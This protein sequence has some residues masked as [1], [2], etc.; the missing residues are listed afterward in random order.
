MRALVLAMVVAGCVRA[1][2]SPPAPV[3]GD[4]ELRAELLRIREADQAERERFGEAMA[5]ND[6]AY[7]LRLL[8]ADSARTRRLQEII[9]RHGWPRVARV[10]KD[11]VQGAFLVVQHSPIHEFQREIL[12]QLEVIAKTGEIPAGEVALLTDRV[13]V[14]Q[15]KPQR[16]GNSFLFVNGR[17]VPHPVEN[18]ARLD[19]L[20]AS[21]GLPPIAEYIRLLGDLYKAPV[22]WPP[23]PSQ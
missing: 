19:E 5:A 22:D 14:N 8:R 3:S 10:G 1:P 15:G 18:M 20:R 6:T 21:V 2:A 4:A 13:L 12:P 9:A 7:L 23:P 11:A 17:L 16:Y